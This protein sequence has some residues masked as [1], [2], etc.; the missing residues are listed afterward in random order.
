MTRPGGYGSVGGRRSSSAAWQ[1]VII[2]M[3]VGFGCAAIFVLMLL[4]LGVLTIEGDQPEVA[5][6][7]TNTPA[8]IVDVQATA[9]SLAQSIAA[10]TVAAIEA[11]ASAQPAMPT[12]IEVAAPTAT[13]VPP[14]PEPGVED[15][16]TIQPTQDTAT[17]TD[18]GVNTSE[19]PPQ[20]LAAASRL[21]RVD[22]GAFQMGTTS[23]EVAAAVRECT[24]RD[25]ASCLVSYGEDSYPQ[26]SVTLNV[27]DIERTEVTNEQYVAF[28]N[29]LGPGSHANG[30]YNQPCVATRSTEEFSPIVFDS[31]NY[32]VGSPVN[33]N[34]P[35]GFVTWY[36]ARKYC[37]T[38]GR[39]L[40]TEAEWEHAARGD[41][42]FIYPWGNIWDV[43][44]AR[45]NRPDPEDVGAFEVGSFPA[46]V[47]P[48]GALDMA[49]NVAEW[50]YDYYSS[51]FYSQPEAG[52][53]NPTGPPSGTER[54]VRGGSWSTPPFFARTVHRQSARP[55]EGYIWLGFRCAADADTTSAAGGG[56][57]N[58]TTT[59]L[60]AVDTQPTDEPLDA[61]PTLP[62]LPSTATS[63]ADP[64]EIPAVP[65]GG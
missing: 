43:T 60:G 63:V 62:P 65:P 5:S 13:P 61:A 36:G 14:S 59:D 39:R 18:A 56:V 28:L 35:V 8:P 48:Y 2:G 20:L 31:Q 6:L 4:T 42:G 57:T 19:I 33:S 22:G 64:T 46:G 26:H 11:T 15:T 9:V 24:E 53:L 12:T 51:I 10:E 38:I 17:Q 32:D 23:Q 52:G 40:P 29:A 25:Q 54:V 45:T 47:S 1:W 50:V 7:P 27:Y 49:G 34:Q 16:P 37:E 58:N 3:T 21:V 44:Y 41:D 30:C 55:N